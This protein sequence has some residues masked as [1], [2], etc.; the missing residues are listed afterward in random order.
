VHRTDSA[1][2]DGHDADAAW[3]PAYNP[4]HCAGFCDAEHPQAGQARGHCTD[5]VKIV[6]H[7]A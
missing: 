6:S 4:D 3:V 2:Q 7:S 1:P 5:Q